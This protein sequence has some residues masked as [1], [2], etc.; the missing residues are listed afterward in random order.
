[1]SPERPPWRTICC[2]VAMLVE[3]RPAQR[4]FVEGTKEIKVRIKMNEG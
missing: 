1:M 3:I 2:V 4:A